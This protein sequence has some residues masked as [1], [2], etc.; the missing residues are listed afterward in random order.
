[1]KPHEAPAH[2]PKHA[3]TVRIG[4]VC[5]TEVLGRELDTRAAHLSRPVFC[6]REAKCASALH[7]QAHAVRQIALGASGLRVLRGLF[8]LAGKHSRRAPRALFLKEKLA[9]KLGRVR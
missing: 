7:G 1:M 6:G 2:E 9:H 3:R 5:P 8:V 4:A